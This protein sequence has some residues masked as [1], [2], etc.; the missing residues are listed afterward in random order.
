[1][2]RTDLRE[3]AVGYQ[4]AILAAEWRIRH[5]REIVMRAPRKKVT[6]NTSAVEAVWNLIGRTATALWN[7][8]ESFHLIDIEVGDA[9]RF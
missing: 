7:A 9:P 6:L 4:W 2:S 5:E 8:E 1:M 3:R